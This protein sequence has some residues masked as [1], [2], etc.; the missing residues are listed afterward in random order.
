M[1]IQTDSRNLGKTEYVTGD[2]EALRVE[3][4]NYLYSS[5]N[6]WYYDGHK[7]TMVSNTCST[8][9]LVRGGYKVLAGHPDHLGD[10]DVGGTSYENES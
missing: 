3:E 1:F 5:P 9:A 8:L 4:V 6:T 2:W 10:L 7:M